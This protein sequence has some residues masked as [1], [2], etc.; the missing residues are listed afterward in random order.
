MIGFLFFF[1]YKQI[2]DKHRVYSHSVKLE[3][4]EQ[5]EALNKLLVIR[6][7]TVNNNFHCISF[8]AVDLTWNGA[9]Q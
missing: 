2:R 1:Y 7:S 5:A 3:P 6:V 9:E 8:V 4:L